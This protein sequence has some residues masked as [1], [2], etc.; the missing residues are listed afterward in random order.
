MQTALTDHLA[1]MHFKRN[2][3]CQTPST[4]VLRFDCVAQVGERKR[5]SS[6]V[7][8]CGIHCWMFHVKACDEMTGTS[9]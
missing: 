1:T 4:L 5:M 2:I 7:V 9:V 8:I 6:S 3:I